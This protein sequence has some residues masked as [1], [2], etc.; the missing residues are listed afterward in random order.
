MEFEDRE[1]AKNKKPVEGSQNMPM[2]VLIVLVGIVCLLLYVGWEM[3]SDEPTKVSDISP[4]M[5][6]STVEEESTDEAVSGEEMPDISIPKAKAP[7]E[8]AVKVEKKVSAVKGGTTITHTVSKGETFY[9]IAN[10]Y[11]L[12][13][14]TLTSY[15]S[16]V[17]PQSIKEGVTKLKVPVKAVHTVGP[18][19]ILR[20]VGSKYDVTVKQLMTANGKTKNVA[21]RGEKLII[22]F[23]TKK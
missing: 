7:V 11:N 8:T 14:S 18:G 1:R 23:G 17:K 21:K 22:P 9:G 6:D 10:R 12:E 13:T 16:S 20:V 15:N 19:D 3:I 2:A 4:T 5:I